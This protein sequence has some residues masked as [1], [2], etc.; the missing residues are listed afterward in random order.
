MKRF[1]IS[2]LSFMCLAIPSLCN[3]VL[4]TRLLMVP[5]EVDSVKVKLLPRDLFTVA[6][7]NRENFD[8]SSRELS[9][10]L[11]FR[12]RDTINFIVTQLLE[13]PIDSIL[14]YNSNVLQKELKLFKLKD[15]SEIAVWFVFDILDLRCRMIIYSKGA[16]QII[17]LSG[18]GY[19]DIGEYRCKATPNLMH[20]LW[21]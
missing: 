19:L 13:S 2:I 12:N 8:E 6:N 1:V 7:I 11:T 21:P 20:F 4:A 18:T 10:T 5:K 3:D 9:Y 16:Y 17:W 14:P 15:G